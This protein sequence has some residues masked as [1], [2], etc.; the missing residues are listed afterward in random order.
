MKGFTGLPIKN[1][2]GIILKQDNIH[3]NHKIMMHS[4]PTHITNDIPSVTFLKDDTIGSMI[5]SDITI[6]DFWHTKCPYCITPLQKFMSESVQYDDITFV[7]CAMNTGPGSYTHT[8][9]ILSDLTEESANNVLHVFAE[10]KELMKNT[11][12]IKTVPHCVAVQRNHVSTLRLLYWGHTD[13]L[14]IP[15]LLKFR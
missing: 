11:F 9:E 14:D 5:G 8:K 7:A 10:D 6:I 2:C 15:L 13:Q 4:A 1:S 12:N 3:E